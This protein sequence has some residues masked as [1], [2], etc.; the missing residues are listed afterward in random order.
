MVTA[1]EMTGGDHGNYTIFRTGKTA[2][3]AVAFLRRN[4]SGGGYS[5]RWRGEAAGV[6]IPKMPRENAAAVLMQR[7]E[8]FSPTKRNK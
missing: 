1:Y 5:L 2:F 4:Q 3:S 8:E 6:H 7:L